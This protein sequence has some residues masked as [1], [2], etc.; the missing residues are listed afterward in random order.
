MP[1]D[2]NTACAAAKARLQQSLNR[3]VAQHRMHIARRF[4]AMVARLVKQGGGA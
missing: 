4:A 2:L 1:L 3:S